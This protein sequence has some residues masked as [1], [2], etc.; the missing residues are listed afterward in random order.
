MHGEERRVAGTRL[1]VGVR[2]T[3]RT[4]IWP[5]R[6]ATVIDISVGGVLIETRH[7]VLPGAI[8]ELHLE[9]G[10]QQIRARG[11]VARCFVSRIGAD[12]ICYRTAIEFD[13]HLPWFT[14][15]PAAYSVPG[16]QT[17]PGRHW[18]AAA[19]QNGL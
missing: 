9:I 15:E 7:R 4:R 19:T 3:V 8:V 1:I 5:G 2:D 16:P 6:H 14:P 13:S 10:A 11:R 18:T 12:V 17:R